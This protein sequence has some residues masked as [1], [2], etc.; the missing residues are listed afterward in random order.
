VSERQKRIEETAHAAHAALERW[1]MGLPARY[2]G[3][4]LTQDD[5]TVVADA[6]NNLRA[7]LLDR[8][9]RRG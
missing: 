3:K 7:A 5:V 8:R 6:S 2:V 9:R 1:L 4:P